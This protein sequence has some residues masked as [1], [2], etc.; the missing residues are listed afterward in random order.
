MVE[1]PDLAASSGGCRRQPRTG[2][3]WILQYVART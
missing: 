2:K 1:L 3:V